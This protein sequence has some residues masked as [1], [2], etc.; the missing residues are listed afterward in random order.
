[1][2]N[3]NFAFWNFLDLFF[4]NIFNPWLVE[5]CGNGTHR[6]RKPTVLYINLSFHLPNL[7]PPHCRQTLYC[8]SHQEAPQRRLN[9]CFSTEN[10]K[11]YDFHKVWTKLQY[12]HGILIFHHFSSQVHQ[13]LKTP[14]K[15]V[16]VYLIHSLPQCF[17]VKLTV[18]SNL[19]AILIIF[20]KWTVLLFI[21]R[22]LRI[23]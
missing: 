12:K 21:R 13:D 9:F 18:A 17:E 4:P 23:N 3:S 15:R 11:A 20:M 19:T 2:A 5:I 1:M 6:H 8:L 7:G 10:L 16:S 14:F 22:S